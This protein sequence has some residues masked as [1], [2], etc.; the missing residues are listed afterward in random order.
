MASFLQ[1]AGTGKDAKNDTAM[2]RFSF[3]VNLVSRC[4]PFRLFPRFPV[5]LFPCSSF[6]LLL[7][8]LSLFASSPATFAQRPGRSDSR[9]S[10]PVEAV[11]LAARELVERAMVV[12]CTEQKKDPKA[13]IP[14]DDMQGRPS[15]SMNSVEAIDGAER[16]QR[17]LPLAKNLAIDSLRKLA[18]DYRLNQ[19]RGFRQK[20]QLAISR[21]QMVR[22]VKPD[23]ESRDNA[24]V[25]LR[26]PYTITF[27]TIF[28][29]GLPSDEGMIS[30]LSHELVHIADGDRDSLRSLF[31]T[32]GDRA[33]GLTGLRIQEQRAEELV[34]DLVGALAARAFVTDT[35]SYD[36]LPRRI[37]RSVEHNC[38]EEDEGDEDHLSPRNT[39]RALLALNPALTRELIYGQEELRPARPTRSN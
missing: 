32:I 27:G 33:A 12:V 38:V 19:T 5:P 15:L 6:P 20:L 31:R 30:V 28:L 14:I 10:H 13:S 2:K 1:R 4:S 3:T 16:A 37:A 39:M 29:A 21:V 11:S 17:L 18:T 34:C 7:I 36:P 8:L 23:M 24:S 25:F 35:P 22:R 26:R 9:S